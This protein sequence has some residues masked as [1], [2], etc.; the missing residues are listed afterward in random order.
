MAYEAHKWKK[1]EEITSDKLN[2]IEKGIEEAGLPREIT[3]PQDGQTLKY[4]AASGK[5]VNGEGGSGSSTLVVSVD[6]ETNALNKTWQEIYD[7]MPNVVLTIFNDSTE[8]R[9]VMHVI[10]C[11]H[12]TDDDS[13][14]VRVISQ[15]LQM[16]DA[17]TTSASG[18]PIF[19]GNYN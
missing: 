15:A 6:A 3:D 4:D 8:D 11:I 19:G 7:A 14:T 13:Y 18:Y 16:S 5:W 9:M 17:V 12:S 1:G 2:H 10:R